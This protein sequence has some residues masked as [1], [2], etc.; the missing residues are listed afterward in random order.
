MQGK[1]VLNLRLKSTVGTSGSATPSRLRTDSDKGLRVEGPA[2]DWRQTSCTAGLRGDKKGPKD[3]DKSFHG[4]GRQFY[5]RRCHWLPRPGH[6][7]AQK[8]SGILPK[9]YRECKKALDATYREWP[10]CLSS[11]P[12][13]TP[14]PCDNV[15]YPR[16]ST[17]TITL[18]SPRAGHRKSTYLIYTEP[19]EGRTCCHQTP[20]QATQA[21]EQKVLDCCVLE[22][23]THRMHMHANMNLF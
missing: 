16:G 10:T 18:G 11:D 7:R 14:E 4:P 5:S 6:T 1:G 17:A 2:K 19:S 23:H 8:T 12:K 3:K 22:P 20:R 15:Q 13:R 9:A 21:Q